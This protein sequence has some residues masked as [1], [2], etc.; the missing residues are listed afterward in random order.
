MTGVQTCALPIYDLY[1]KMLHEA[2]KQEKGIEPPE[3][4]ETSIDVAIDAFIPASYISNEAQR[5]DMYKRIAGVETEEEKEDMTEELI[6][7]FG[8]PPKSVQ[9]L[10]MLAEYKA[11]AHRRYFTEVA[12]KGD[13]I[14]FALFERAKM[15]PAKIPE[16]VGL[17]QGKMK[18][19]ADKKIPCFVY[20]M[21]KNSRK[22][23]SAAEV[24]ADVLKHA[25]M[26]CADTP[27]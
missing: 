10:L 9:N 2:V 19:Y 23:E 20:C 4:Y 22:S 21:Q 1:C 14:R 18:F 25:K 17:F 8:E 15:N 27:E 3:S 26:L 13:E 16:F 7:R 6:D 12:Q 5:L 24:I 11:L